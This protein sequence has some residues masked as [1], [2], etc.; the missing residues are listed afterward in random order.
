MAG[1]YR[2]PHQTSEMKQIE[3][4]NQ[5]TPTTQRFARLSPGD[6]QPAEHHTS[7]DLGS[8]LQAWR[9]PRFGELDAQIAA[10]AERYLDKRQKLNP[11]RQSNPLPPAVHQEVTRLAQELK[12]D[13][14]L[15]FINDPKLRDRAARCFRSQLPPFGQPG[16]PG[17]NDVTAA[18]ELLS[19]LRRDYARLY[20]HE[21]PHQI[22]K[23]VWKR[24]CL[25][26]IPNYGTITEREQRDT[27]QRLQ[28]RV[29]DRLNKRKRS[30]RLK[31]A[32]G[33]SPPVSPSQSV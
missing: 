11:P 23:R 1:T 20:P 15:L 14:S 13:H 6:P 25:E 19:R 4:R 8:S 24:I 18:I 12:R 21:K 26:V 10:E 31:T 5:M 9:S 17:Y 32:P 28:R 3:A 27:C 29:R 7:A 22:G 16:A 2:V 30:A 33:N